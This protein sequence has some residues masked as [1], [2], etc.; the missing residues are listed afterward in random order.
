MIIYVFIYI[1]Y[2][3]CNKCTNIILDWHASMDQWP[4]KLENLHLYAV[5]P[6]ND[7]FNQLKVGNHVCILIQFDTYN[8]ICRCIRTYFE[9]WETKVSGDWRHLQTKLHG[10][11]QAPNDGVTYMLLHDDGFL[12]WCL[13]VWSGCPVLGE[14]TSPKGEGD[15]VVV[16]A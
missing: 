2:V 14:A 8:F 15:R 11:Q 6:Q 7:Q 16:A 5:D 1:I 13:P 3:I 10:H 9:G 12:S 4:L